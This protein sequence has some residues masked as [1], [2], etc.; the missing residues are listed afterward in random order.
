[1][2]IIATST[3]SEVN[4]QKPKT[5]VSQ[6]QFDEIVKLQL[7]SRLLGLMREGKKVTP[8]LET[9]LTKKVAMIVSSEY[10][11]KG[12]RLGHINHAPV[13]IQE[14]YNK[15]KEIIS[16]LTWTTNEIDYTI[17]LLAKKVA[18]ESK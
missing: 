17:S 7:D 18:T 16:N 15:A 12:S 10:R 6:E 2:S 1:M 4:N 14:A 5:S 8:Q 11:V 13:E 3:K 9:T